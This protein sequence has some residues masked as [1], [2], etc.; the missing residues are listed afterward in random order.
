MLHIHF[1]TGRLGLGLVAPFFQKPGAELH[2]LNRAESGSKA[3]GETRL[4]ARRR[5]ELLLHNP[6]KQYVIQSPSGAGSVQEKEVRETVHYDGFHPY[7]CDNI[8]QI[9]ETILAGS[10]GKAQAVV[11]TASVLT[12][13]NYSAVVD[14]LN[15]ICETKESGEPVGNVYLVAC[16]NTLNAEE[17]LQHE[18]F[19]TKLSESTKR[20]VRCVPALVDRMCVGIEEHPGGA[21]PVLEPAVAVQ[22]E[23]YG[24]L[25]MALTPQT[26]RLAEAVGGSRVEFSRHL[27]VEKEIKNWLLNGTHWLIALTAFH[28]S[29]GDAALKLNEWINENEDHHVLAAEILMEMRDGVEILL[30]SEP[31]YRCFVEDVRV[32]RYLDDAVEAVLDRFRSNEDTM[33]RILARF[34][35]PSPQEVST[36]Q[37]FTSRLLGRV[38]PPMAAYQRERGIPPRAATQ[39]LFNLFRLQAAGTFVDQGSCKKAA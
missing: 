9:M 16:E 21:P 14:A 20:H 37:S 38:D 23:E 22:A 7:T 27:E 34:R 1:G 11:V 33:T 5:N 10:P 6:Q 8:G 35:T 30:R 29:G 25:K 4:D 17:V 18:N 36:L 3:T 26:E 19:C 2:L 32:T 13:E 15:V 28:E 24:L 31:Q 12:A 39:S